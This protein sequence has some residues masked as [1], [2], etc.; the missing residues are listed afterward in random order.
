MPVHLLA[1]DSAHD[2]SEVG[3]LPDVLVSTSGF[4]QADGTM[5]ARG[6]CLIDAGPLLFPLKRVKIRSQLEAS[7]T[8]VSGLDTGVV[9]LRTMSSGRIPLRQGAGCT[10]AP[11]LSFLT[12]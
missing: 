3:H 9:Q 10:S 11:V 4:L 7:T 6:W 8:V 5:D 2:C 1:G 12:S